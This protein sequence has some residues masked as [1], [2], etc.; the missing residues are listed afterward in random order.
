LKEFPSL[1]DDNLILKYAQKA[2]TVNVS[3]VPRENRVSISITRQKQ[4]KQTATAPPPKLSITESIGNLQKRAF[5]WGSREN[6]GS[7]TPAKGTP[8]SD[9]RKRKSSNLGPTERVLPGDRSPI[10]GPERVQ[11]V[12]ISEEWV[13]TGD[14]VK[15]DEIRSAH[16][17][18]SSPDIALFKVL[19][20]SLIIFLG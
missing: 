9:Q 7:S 13:L 11:F 4:K 15:D 10:D 5:S 2:I 14:L 8:N 3:S 16:R 17:Y 1:R 19:S 20:S 18:T 12:S 6:G